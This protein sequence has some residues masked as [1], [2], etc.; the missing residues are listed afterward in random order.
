MKKMR[1]KKKPISAEAT[2]RMADQGKVTGGQMMNPFQRVNVDFTA[3]MLRELD[4]PEYQPPDGHQDPRSRGLGQEIFPARVTPGEKSSRPWFDEV[5]SSGGKIERVVS[6]WM[7][8]NLDF[9]HRSLTLL[10]ASITLKSLH[11][12]TET[13]RETHG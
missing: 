3:E 12:G 13:H 1:K 11:T 6:S 4:K 7:S 5:P 8:A 9:L 2:A 10:D